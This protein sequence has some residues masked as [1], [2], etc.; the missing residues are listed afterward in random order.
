MLLHMTWYN[1]CIGCMSNK[2][3]L[4]VCITDTNGRQ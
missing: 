4:T 1:W 2:T 3:Q